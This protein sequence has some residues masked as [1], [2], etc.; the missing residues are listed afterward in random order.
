MDSQILSFLG[1]SGLGLLLIVLVFSGGC[2]GSFTGG[3]RPFPSTPLPT[4]PSPV[5]ESTVP[6]LPASLSAGQ[7]FPGYFS[8]SDQ[9]VYP[10]IVPD[11]KGGIESLVISYQFPFENGTIGISVPVNISVYQGAHGADRNITIPGS[12]PPSTLLQ[13]YYLSF[14]G[15]PQQGQFFASL[16]EEFH[17]HQKSLNLTSDEYL[18]MLTTFVQSLSYEPHPG[19]SKFP[20]ETFV[21]RSGDCDDKA[22]LL[23]ALLA[24]EDFNV[25]LLYFE[26]EHHLALGVASDANGFRDSGYAYVET[27]YPSFIGAVPERIEGT[28]ILSDPPR[29]LRIGNGTGKYD[30]GLETQ[31]IGT[32]LQSAE[33][34]IR[35]SLPN[36]PAGRQ[37]LYHMAASGELVAQYQAL[38]GR[39]AGYEQ[40]VH[41]VDVFLYLLS[42]SY[43]RKGT[44][45][46][47]DGAV[48]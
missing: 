31:W 25:S 1:R 34:F 19:G 3:H 32:T 47:L 18:E 22:L 12:T 24:R 21:D 8:R 13:D 11:A 41:Q 2:I 48:Q 37:E 33:R 17:I 28:G 29:I 39:D 20:I 43:D 36:L 26:R 42:H 23:A 27:T 44:I 14:V 10:R 45:A 5:P 4:T 35:L 7:P 46:W 16:L 40:L 9:A 38:H 6:S 30:S 15:D